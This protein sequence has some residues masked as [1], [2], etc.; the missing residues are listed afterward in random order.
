MAPGLGE[1]I[2]GL[3]MTWKNYNNI[4]IGSVSILSTL[5]HRDALSLSK[6]LLVLP[7]VMHKELLLF[8]CRKNTLFRSI[9]ALISA[10]PELFFNFNRRYESALV[11]SLNAIQLLI[12][13][14]LVDYTEGFIYQ[15]QKINIDSSFGERAR[16]IVQASEKISHILN[17]SEE[18]LYLNL[19]IKL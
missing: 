5:N 10:H 18:E 6:S 14:K 2:Q 1:R 4:G 11:T 19:R 17:S 15:K 8:L 7:L 16:R 13:L 9:T 12:E 3:V